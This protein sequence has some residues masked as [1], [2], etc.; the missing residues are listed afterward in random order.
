M[1]GVS[2]NNANELSDLKVK[3]RFAVFFVF[4]K[5]Y[6]AYSWKSVAGVAGMSD[7]T[8]LRRNGESGD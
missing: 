2:W 5:M 6:L 3:F 4:N 1:W 7:R 8:F